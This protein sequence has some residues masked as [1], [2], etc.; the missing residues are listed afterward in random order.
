MADPKKTNAAAAAPV[1]AAAPVVEA[2]VRVLRPFH[3][4]PMYDPFTNVMYTSE[5]VKEVPSSWVDSQV[6]AGKLVAE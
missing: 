6:E 5:G 1:T 4:G 3:G 2:V